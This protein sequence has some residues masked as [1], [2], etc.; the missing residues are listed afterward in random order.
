MNK[1]TA[2]KIGMGLLLGGL[3]AFTSNF[4]KRQIDL[5]KQSDWD[6]AGV[7]ITQLSFNKVT[8]KLDWK[9]I[10]KSSISAEVSNQDYDVFLNDIFIKKIGYTAPIEIKAGSD[11]I[12]P[13][14]I[15][16]EPDDLKKIG[17]SNLGKF[18]TKEGRESLTLKVVG[19]FDVKVEFIKINRFPFEYEDTIENIY[20]Y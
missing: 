20:N 2:I 8:I 18:L 12:I 17:L 9:I 10:N 15:T 11:T 1:I 19:S 4:I 7:K 14:Y 6:F 16:I 13:T 3:I 5:L